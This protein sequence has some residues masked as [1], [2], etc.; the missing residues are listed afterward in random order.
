MIIIH[1]QRSDLQSTIC[2]NDIFL[3]SVNNTG[4]KLYQNLSGDLKDL[5][6]IKLF[7][8][9]VKS[10]LL[11]QTIYSV[12]QSFITENVSLGYDDLV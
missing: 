11:Q 12:L 9:K 1:G 7:R 5:N 8:R 3:K 2:R 6:K 10:I 4:M